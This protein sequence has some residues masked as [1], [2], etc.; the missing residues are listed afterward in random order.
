MYEHEDH[1]LGQAQI[2]SR[3]EDI[4]I[5]PV[6]RGLRLEKRPHPVIIPRREKVVR[7]AVGI[8]EVQLPYVRIHWWYYSFWYAGANSSSGHH[9]S[10]DERLT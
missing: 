10:L 7:V 6:Q 1:L 8:G 4:R 9:P 3:I 5:E 2:P